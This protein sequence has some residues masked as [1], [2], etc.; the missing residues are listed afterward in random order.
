MKLLSNILI[1]LIIII[2]LI[3][4]I[5]IALVLSFANIIKHIID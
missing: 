5:P 4:F 1:D 3:L 2:F